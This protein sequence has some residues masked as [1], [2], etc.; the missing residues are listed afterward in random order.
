MVRALLPSH[1]DFETVF[2]EIQRNNVCNLIVGN[3]YTTPGASID[4]FNSSFDYCLDKVTNKGKLC[5]LMGDF[6]L[7]LL[8]CARHRPADD[9]VNTLFS[10]G[11]DD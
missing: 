7:N 10:Y 3:V 2:I 5:N 6:A 8:F 4:F 11:T 1:D 9:F